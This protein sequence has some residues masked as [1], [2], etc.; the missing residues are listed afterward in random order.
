M[1][2]LS[3]RALQRAL[4]LMHVRLAEEA[5]HSCCARWGSTSMT[6]WIWDSEA[7]KEAD[8]RERRP[9]AR[10]CVEAAGLTHVGHGCRA[11][12]YCSVLWLWSSLSL[13]ERMN[14]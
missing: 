10:G 2:R 1:L 8:I 9:A 4:G 3:R 12:R 6:A 13:H 14:R 5:A 7:T 11:S